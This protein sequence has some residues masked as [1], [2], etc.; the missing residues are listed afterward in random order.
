MLLETIILDNERP[1]DISLAQLRDLICR[2][3]QSLNDMSVCYY[4]F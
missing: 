3:Y 1:R 4:I 2:V